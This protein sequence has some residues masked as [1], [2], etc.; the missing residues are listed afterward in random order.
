MSGRY[1]YCQNP[2]C[3]VYL[4]SLGGNSCWICGWNA[5]R[6]EDDSDNRPC[7]FCFQRGCNGECSGDGAMGD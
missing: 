5:G 6:D 7:S 2:S 4:G 3:G 1:L